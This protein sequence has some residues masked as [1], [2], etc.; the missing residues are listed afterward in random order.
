MPG[1]ALEDW[2]D[3]AGGT[4]A[5]R[6][7][8]LALARAAVNVSGELQ[9]GAL[10][11]APSDLRGAHPAVDDERKILERYGNE[12]FLEEVRGAPVAQ[13]GRAV[14]GVGVPR[15]RTVPPGRL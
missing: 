4:P 1:K 13:S 9:S 10:S 15:M 2:L 11:L 5:V 6:S 8:I 12:C 14:P 3:E 7:T